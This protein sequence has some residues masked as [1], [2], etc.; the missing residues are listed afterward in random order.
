[1]QLVNVGNCEMTARLLPSHPLQDRLLFEAASHTGAL[2]A[3][4]QAQTG[5]A[6]SQPNTLSQRCDTLARTSM[7]YQLIDDWLDHAGDPAVMG[8]RRR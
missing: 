6:I 8:K 4:K 2:I 3:A 5:G 7:A 1:M